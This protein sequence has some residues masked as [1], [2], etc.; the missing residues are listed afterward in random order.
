MVGHKNFTKINKITNKKKALHIY[1]DKKKWSDSTGISHSPQ[2]Q[3]LS[4][5]RSHDQR[6]ISVVSNAYNKNKNKHPSN[7]Y[8]YTRCVHKL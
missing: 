8:F 4:L 2:M 7:F 1:I 3:R 6:G 5:L